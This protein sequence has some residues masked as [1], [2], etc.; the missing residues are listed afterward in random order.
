MNGTRTYNR[1]EFFNFNFYSRFSIHFTATWCLVDE[2]A[3]FGKI[4]KNQMSVR[5]VYSRQTSMQVIKLPRSSERK[6]FSIRAEKPL[7]E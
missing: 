4:N 5:E 2:S 7:R 6:L 3:C 1:I